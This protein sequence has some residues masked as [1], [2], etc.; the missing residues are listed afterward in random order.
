MRTKN[1]QNKKTQHHDN[2]GCSA[3]PPAFEDE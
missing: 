1:S 3:A 2:S